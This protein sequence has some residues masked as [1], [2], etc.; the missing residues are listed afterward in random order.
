MRKPTKA[1]IK[2]VMKQYFQISWLGKDGKLHDG[3]LKDSCQIVIIHKINGAFGHHNCNPKKLKSQ[4]AS[5]IRSNKWLREDYVIMLNGEE[6]KGKLWRID[7][8]LDGYEN[9]INE[10][11]ESAKVLDGFMDKYFERLEKKLKKR[12]LMK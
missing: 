1:L 4:T 9:F 6:Y 10:A 12:G 7:K 3:L 5:F 8:K 11:E 2:K